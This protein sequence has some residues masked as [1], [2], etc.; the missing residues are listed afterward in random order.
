M[1]IAQNPNQSN[2]KK[3]P[4]WVGLTNFGSDLS[5]DIIKSGVLNKKGTGRSSTRNISLRTYF[6]NYW[7]YSFDKIMRE[8]V[9]VMSLPENY[10]FFKAIIS[11]NASS[12]D[13]LRE[14]CSELVDDFV[15]Q[16]ISPEIGLDVFR[17]IRADFPDR[18]LNSGA[19]LNLTK[20]IGDD[21]VKVSNPYDFI[22]ILESV[23]YSYIKYAK[24]KA[25]GGKS[26]S[27]LKYFETSGLPVYQ[28]AKEAYRTHKEE[29]KSGGTTSDYLDNI[30]AK[31]IGDVEF[32]RASP[33]VLDRVSKELMRIYGY[34]ADD[35]NKAREVVKDPQKVIPIYKKVAAQY[36]K[37]KQDE[38]ERIAKNQTRLQHLVGKSL[39]GSTLGLDK[40]FDFLMR[41]PE[42]NVKLWKDKKN[43]QKVKEDEDYKKHMEVLDAK[44]NKTTHKKK[45]VKDAPKTGNK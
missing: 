15:N 43:S 9:G 38:R 8:I 17:Q 42:E 30:L 34:G 1:A 45:I 4:K 19:F 7:Q 3:E 33:E 29:Y 25:L 22:A 31:S 44:K 12:D 36:A 40:A 6:S 26:I 2:E 28:Y 14:K 39:K 13:M 10:H 27:F 41:T 20:G 11:Y 21:N 16:L 5:A 23:I 32:S 24:N 35:I 37:E 18:F